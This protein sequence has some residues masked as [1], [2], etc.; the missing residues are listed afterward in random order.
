MIQSDRLGEM[1]AECTATCEAKAFRRHYDQLCTLIQEP[2]LPGLGASFFSHQIIS[3]EVLENVSKLITP[4]ATKTTQLLLAVMAHLEVHPDVF[5][6]VLDIFNHVEPYKT[7][8]SD[9][10]ETHRKFKAI[11][12]HPCREDS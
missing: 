3:V 11:L 7:V 8:S 12:Y 5:Q 2:D 6:T 10:K 4:K 9:M 1:A